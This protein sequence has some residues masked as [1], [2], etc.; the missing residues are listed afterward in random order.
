M[1][2]NYLRL[3][4]YPHD[5]RFARIADEEGILLRDRN[6]AGVITWSGGKENADTEERLGFMSNLS[7][8][9]N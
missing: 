8:F 3:A 9:Q 1:N 4:H 7:L 2:G 5:Q 6:R